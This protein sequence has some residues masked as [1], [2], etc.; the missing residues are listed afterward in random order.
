MI[1][2][3][4]IYFR[5]LGKHKENSIFNITIFKQ[6]QVTEDIPQLVQ[7][8]QNQQITPPAE[9]NVQEKIQWKVTLTNYNA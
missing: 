7:P 3:H 9:S 4:S 2:N 6:E 1:A 8:Q 5:Y